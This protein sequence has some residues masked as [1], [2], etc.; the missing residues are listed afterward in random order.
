MRSTRI[1][2]PQALAPGQ[3]ITLEAQASRH[4][5]RALRMG[6]GDEL[7]LFDGSGGEYVAHI[8][9]TDKHAV[10][11]TTG[12]HRTG[13]PE[14]PLRIHLG[15]AVSRGER[16]DWAI[17]KATELGVAAITPLLTE[18]TGVKLPPDR[19]EKKRQHW[20]QVIVSACEQSGRCVLPEL[21]PLST[22]QAW[23]DATTAARR[24]ILQP[25]S[26]DALAGDPV[27]S[28]ALLVGP[29]GG[30]S[31]PEVEG[32][33]SAGFEPLQLGPRVLRTETAP[34]A[35]IALLQGLWGDLVP[36]DG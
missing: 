25:G 34:L 20:R 33:S 17:Q 6:V 10:E 27:D 12:E 11:V 18:R 29:E 15:L 23:V 19:A 13:V 22:L 16:M 26:R 1:Y 24:F 3:Q 21:Q 32:S 9:A 35:A 8:S 36:A 4:L 2:T 28:V 31:D 5:S 14:S 30:F 7:A